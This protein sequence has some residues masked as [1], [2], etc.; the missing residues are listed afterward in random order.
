MMNPYQNGG[1]PLPPTRPA[2]MNHSQSRPPPPVAPQAF[3]NR[4]PPPPPIG[5]AAH[6]QG[7]TY[8]LPPFQPQYFPPPPA[9]VQFHPP[10]NQWIPQQYYPPPGF[11]LPHYGTY[12]NLPSPRPPPPAPL[13][14]PPEPNLLAI[15]RNGRLPELTKS[16]K[17][18]SAAASTDLSIPEEITPATT[19]T[20]G[21]EKK[22]KKVSEKGST[23]V[24]VPTSNKKLDLYADIFI[25]SLRVSRKISSHSS[26]NH[27]PYS[28]PACLVTRSQRRSSI[29]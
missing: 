12:P 21:G 4:P 8:H 11:R 28:S 3:W 14:N 29:L 16:K 6:F 10:P 17:A 13:F 24:K 2:A 19:P 18:V 23:N 15:P 27:F 9:P 1:V 20:D 5:P 25:V 26:L 22:Q 7:Q